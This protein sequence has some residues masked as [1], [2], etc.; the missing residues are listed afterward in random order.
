MVWRSEV[1]IS[2]PVVGILVGGFC[3]IGHVDLVLTGR[4]HRDPV[5]SVIRDLPGSRIYVPECREDIPKDIFPKRDNRPTETSDLQC[6]IASVHQAM[7]SGWMSLD[8]D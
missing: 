2:H 3:E 6:Q 1:I 8:P 7:S 4:L 5:V